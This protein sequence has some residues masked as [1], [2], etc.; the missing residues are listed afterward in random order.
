MA[1]IS[2]NRRIR[3][4]DLELRHDELTGQML[5]WWVKP[6]HQEMVGSPPVAV[7][8]PEI[9]IEM[10]LY[11]QPTMLITPTG[12]VAT[13]TGA[14]R[15]N[16][17]ARDEPKYMAGTGRELNCVVNATDYTVTGLEGG[18]II[19]VTAENGTIYIGWGDTTADENKLIAVATNTTHRFTLPNTEVQYHYSTEDGAGV[20]G[21]HSL[22][23]D[24]V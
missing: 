8:V 21:R 6:A 4:N 7:E 14:G 17:S 19:E 13:I 18:D 24:E 2:L 9:E 20:I 5:L 1:A 11:M 23:L 3:P 15:L 16:V 12:E 22:I 10:G